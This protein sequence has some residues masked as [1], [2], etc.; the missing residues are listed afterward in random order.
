MFYTLITPDFL[1]KLEVDSMF[2]S[3][4]LQKLLSLHI[5]IDVVPYRT[6]DPLMTINKLWQ[7]FA[8]WQCRN[9]HYSF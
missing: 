2:V 1:R 8:K 6:P 9:L 5:P 3:G 4:F 7:L